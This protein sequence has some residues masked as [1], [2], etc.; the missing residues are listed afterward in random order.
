[1]SN[2]E[3][4]LFNGK[5]IK[6]KVDKD[7]NVWY[8]RKIICTLTYKNKSKGTKYFLKNEQGE[9]LFTDNNRQTVG[10][11]AILNHIVS[12]LQLEDNG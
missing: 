4:K 7:L 12:G 10:K 8:K 3:F 9:T 1:M 5:T 6:Y 2:S 11:Y